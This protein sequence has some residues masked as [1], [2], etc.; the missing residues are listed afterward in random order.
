MTKSDEFAA[1]VYERAQAKVTAGVTA[2][3]F[4]PLL[5]PLIQ[6]AI[7]MLIERMGSCGNN[8]TEVKEYINSDSVLARAVTNSCCSEAVRDYWNEIRRSERGPARRFLRDAILEEA[9]STSDEE[10]D[11]AID[12][13]SDFDFNPFSM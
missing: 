12:E 8:N 10:L 7:S 5:L 3:Q 4:L 13:S 9:R 1:R 2:F 11:E 6:A